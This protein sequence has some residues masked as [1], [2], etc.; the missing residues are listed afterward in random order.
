LA[1]GL[2]TFL[3]LRWCRARGEVL[4]NFT[5]PPDAYPPEG[6]Y[7]RFG[8]NVREEILLAAT[9]AIPVIVLLAGLGVIALAVRLNW[10][11]T[12][13]RAGEAACPKCESSGIRPAKSRDLLDRIFARSF[14][15]PFRCRT[16][17][18]RFYLYVQPKM[19]AGTHI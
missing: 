8:R 13:R 4:S 5:V 6:V 18:R 10:I 19:R 7:L 9:M 2:W 12:H 3:S 1:F 15:R 14:C 16:C 11:R 17:R